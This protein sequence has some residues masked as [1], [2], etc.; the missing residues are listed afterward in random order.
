MPSEGRDPSFV[1]LKQIGGLAVFVES[2][3]FV[4]LNP[5]AD[6]TDISWCL[7]SPWS[8]SPARNS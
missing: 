5:D 3:R 8:V 7:D 1:L 6:Q 2:A 4:F